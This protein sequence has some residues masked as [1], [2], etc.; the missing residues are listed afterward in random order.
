ME[1][2]KRVAKRR[3]KRARRGM[4]ITDGDLHILK[5]IHDFRLLRIHDLEALT[6]RKYKPLHGR[7]KGLFDHRYLGRLELPWKKDIYYITHSGLSLLLRAGLITDEQAAR[8]VREGELTDERFLD[9]ELMITDLHVL[10]TLATRNSRFELLEWKQGTSIHDSFETDV[11]GQPLSIVIEPDAFFTLRETISATGEQKTRSFLVETDRSTMPKKA[12]SGSRRF[13]D[14]FY[15]YEHYLRAGRPWQILPVEQISILSLALNR[16]RRDSL[17][18][19]A[20]ENLSEKFHKYFFLF[21]SLED[22]SRD[23]PATIFHPVFLWPGDVKASRPL[24]PW[25]Q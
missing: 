17:A 21:G 19:S 20:A 2:V 9:H 7:I 16:L 23:D 1:E 3:G 13:H 11:G 6:G 22:F 24:L 4:V 8:R 18:E 10:L 25:L 5:F 14:K 15:K 12:R